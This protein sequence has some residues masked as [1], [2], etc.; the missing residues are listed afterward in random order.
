MVFLIENK[1]KFQCAQK[2]WTAVQYETLKGLECLNV[3][4]FENFSKSNYKSDISKCTKI[5][6]ALQYEIVFHDN[7]CN[8][9]AAK[10]L[11]SFVRLWVA[12]WYETCFF[13]HPMKTVW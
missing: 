5:C 11:M 4:H 12:L 10:L 1:Y 6:A 3:F 2:I 13:T 9:I 7:V 8:P